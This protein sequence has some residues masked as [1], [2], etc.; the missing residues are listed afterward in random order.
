MGWNP[1]HW[2]WIEHLAVWPL[3]ILIAG[4]LGGFAWLSLTD[5]TLPDDGSG[6]PKTAEAGTDVT[7]KQPSRHRA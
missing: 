7:R 5:P 6:V 1:A 4:I 3:L 2:S